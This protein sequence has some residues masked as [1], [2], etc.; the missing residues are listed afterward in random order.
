MKRDT[1]YFNCDSSLH[2]IDSSLNTFPGSLNEANCIKEYEINRGYLFYTAKGRTSEGMV[3]SLR[4]KLIKK[5][6]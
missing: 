2:F 3:V 6:D 4:S 1:L 5:S